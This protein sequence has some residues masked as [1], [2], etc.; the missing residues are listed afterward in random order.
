MATITELSDPELHELLAGRTPEGL[1]DLTPL[2]HLAAAVRRRM[3]AEPAPVMRYPL[4]HALSGG[5]QAAT[6]RYR[7][8]AGLVTAGLGIAAFGAA[9]AA[10]A[11][12][13]PIQN[14]VAEAGDL[15]GVDVPRADDDHHV[16]APFSGTAGP[17]EAED[18]GNEAKAGPHHTTPGGATPA[19]PGT[20]GDQEPSAPA[21]PP[22]QNSVSNPNPDSGTADPDDTADDAADDAADNADDDADNAADNAD[23]AAGNANGRG[24]D[25]LDAGSTNAQPNGTTDVGGKA[26]RA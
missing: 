22:D 16:D 12:P 2:A 5:T 23:D 20:P 24:T 17:G 11:L 13:A 18:E 14:A 9:S 10:N 1:D 25:G 6:P 8:L 26:R 15:V 21:I 7:R 3:E 19:D 4:R